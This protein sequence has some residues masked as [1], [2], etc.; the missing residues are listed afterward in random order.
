MEE[1]YKEL[2]DAGFIAPADPHNKYASCPTMPAKK[3]ELGQWVE[4]RFR[5]RLPRY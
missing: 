5:N 1:K 4:R 3:N 2:L